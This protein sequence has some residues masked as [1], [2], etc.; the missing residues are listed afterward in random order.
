MSWSI[1]MPMWLQIH[2][3]PDPY[4]KKEIVEKLLK[5]AGEIPEMCLN[6]NICGDYVRVKVNHDIQQPLTK[7]VSIVRAKERQV[8]LVH[9]E[10][11][12]RFCKFCGLVG[13]E[14]KEC[15]L[16]IHGEKKLKF[17]DS[18]Y[19]DGP[20]RSRS[21]PNSSREN[22]PCRIEKNGDPI[23]PTD[24][25]LRNKDPETLDTATSPLKNPGVRMEVDRYARK[26]M[27][28]DNDGATT[29]DTPNNP[30]AFLAITDGPKASGILPTLQNN[31]GV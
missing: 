11:I 18:M 7:F 15:G 30:K 2:K 14:H 26:R 5:G 16:G 4:C 22:G 6:G 25:G 29:L 1:T 23:A 31:V 10:K 9:Y 20:N 28:L 3:L 13:H 21:E 27:N 24:L 12:A 8:Y 19:A 17:G